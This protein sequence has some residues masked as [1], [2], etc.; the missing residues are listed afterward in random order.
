MLPVLQAVTVDL[1]LLTGAVLF[2]VGLLIGWASRA[3]LAR[4]WA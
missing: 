3:L 1:G 2:A 4:L